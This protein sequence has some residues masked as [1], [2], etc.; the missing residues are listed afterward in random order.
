VGGSHRQAGRPSHGLARRVPGVPRAGPHAGG[1]PG[2]GP[3]PGRVMG[4]DSGAPAS[5]FKSK[6]AKVSSTAE[7]RTASRPEAA[8]RGHRRAG[9]AVTVTA[10]AVR[11]G[12]RRPQS[13]SLARFRRPA[14]GARR[15][16]PHH[17]H[18]VSAPCPS[19]IR[20]MPITGRGPSQPPADGLRAGAHSLPRP[21]P[22]AALGC[23]PPR[24]DAGP[25]PAATDEMI[26]SAPQRDKLQH[27][28][29]KPQRCASA[30][31]RFSLQHKGPEH[32][33]ARG[34]SG[35]PRR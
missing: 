26:T 18:H 31:G 16:C 3:G 34:L 25:D 1:R 23:C 32:F 29:I 6:P 7:N 28:P 8:R 24:S 13:H 19:R 21:P 12:R 15:Q 33:Q 14:V 11:S 35:H 9:T 4:G 5:Q 2:P 10:A 20:T 22:Q 17:A 30:L 27:V